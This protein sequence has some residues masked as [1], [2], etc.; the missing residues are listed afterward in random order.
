MSPER[1]KKKK[2]IKSTLSKVFKDL[3]DDG[4]DN[5]NDDEE[6]DDDS[7]DVDTDNDDSMFDGMEELDNLDYTVDDDAASRKPKGLPDLTPEKKKKKR[8]VDK[9][10]TPKKESLLCTLWE[11]ESHLYD[12]KS[13]IY[14]DGDLRRKAMKRF[15][16]ALDI[17]GKFIYK[18]N[19]LQISLCLQ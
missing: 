12:S 17:P 3:S 11:E 13:E 5:D 19:V 6:V 16:A 8:K 9:I 1:K 18:K 4:D 7:D 14:K 15:S 2:S 10:W